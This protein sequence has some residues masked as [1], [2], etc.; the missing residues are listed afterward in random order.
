MALSS[1]TIPAYTGAATVYRV[2]NFF[3]QVWEA[4]SNYRRS[5]ATRNALYKLDDHQLE[6]IGL[7][8]GWINDLRV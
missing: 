7:S 3:E 5:V 4:F 8:R 2:V 6:D 1:N